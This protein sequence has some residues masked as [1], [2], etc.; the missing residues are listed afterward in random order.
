MK[1]LGEFLNRETFDLALLE[2]VGC[3]EL[4]WWNPGLGSGRRGE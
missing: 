3:M 1:R 2:E 4:V